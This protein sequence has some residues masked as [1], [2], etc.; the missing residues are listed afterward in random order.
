[1]GMDNK[2]RWGRIF[3]IIKEEEQHGKNNSK[4]NSAGRC[5]G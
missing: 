4:C 5:E 2:I 3:L 1:M